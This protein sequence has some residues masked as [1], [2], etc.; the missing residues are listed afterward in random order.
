MEK[1]EK[2]AWETAEGFILR[3]LLEKTQREPPD[4]ITEDLY[5]MKTD[6]LKKLIE[7]NREIER[8][9]RVDTNPPVD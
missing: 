8:L 3:L 7:V 9:S 1:T 4:P 5:D 2:T 6:L